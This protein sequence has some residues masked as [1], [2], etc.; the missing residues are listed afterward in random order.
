M[1]RLKL[2]LL[3]LA[4]V[5]FATMGYSQINLCTEDPVT[6]CVT[7]IGAVVG[8]LQ[9]GISVGSDGEAAWDPFG[10]G[11]D[12]SDGISFNIGNIFTPDNS[13]GAFNPG[14]WTQINS[15]QYGPYTWVLPASTP[16]GNE[17]EPACEPVAYFTAPGRAFTFGLGSYTMYE[18]TGGW[19]DT[20][21]LSNG[22]PGGIAEIAF[23]SD[24]APEPGVVTLLG[25]ELL[26]VIALAGLKLKRIF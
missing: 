2:L 6:G 5:V 18:S 24:P 12:T 10:A 20:I 1:S 3:V 21:T 16:C 19:S 22:G 4:L 11:Y 8:G 14:F 9:V 25:C 15:T 23:S 13:N 7:A 17:N 26:G